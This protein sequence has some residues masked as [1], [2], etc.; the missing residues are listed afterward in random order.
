MQLDEDATRYELKNI[1]LAVFCLCVLG[2]LL[3]LSYHL[4][5]IQPPPRV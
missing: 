3:F 5:G 2:S 1:A 4:L